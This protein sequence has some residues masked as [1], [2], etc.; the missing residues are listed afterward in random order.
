MLE[1]VTICFIIVELTH[2][3][4]N[5]Y[6]AFKYAC[7]CCLVSISI[8]ISILIYEGNYD[9]LH[10]KKIFWTILSGL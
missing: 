2:K 7:V 1:Q 8:V 9:I 5:L 6:N 10:E 4:V 3:K